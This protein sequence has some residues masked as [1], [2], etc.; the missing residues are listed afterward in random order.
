MS[1]SFNLSGD[2]Y[3][4]D[5]ES[6]DLD[7]V[8]ESDHLIGNSSLLAMEEYIPSINNNTLWQSSFGF[9]INAEYDRST[10]D[11]NYNNLGITSNSTIHLTKNWLFTYATGINLLT[12][13]MYSQSIKLLRDLH[14][15]ELGFTWWPTGS[16][17]GFRLNINVKNPDLQDIKIRSSSSNMEWAN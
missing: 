6:S 11:W 8:S 2:V 3:T 7:N 9:N 1:Q 13:E 14:C 12:M 15:W 10:N 17:K 5:L 16:S 4:S